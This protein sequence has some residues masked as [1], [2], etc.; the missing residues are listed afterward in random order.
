MFDKKDKARS[1]FTFRLGLREVVAGMDVVMAINKLDKVHRG[2]NAK[3]AAAGCTANCAPLVGV[4][5]KCK[6]RDEKLRPVQ[7]HKRRQCLD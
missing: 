1:P 7:G 6:T 3:V 5:N 4:S 2:R